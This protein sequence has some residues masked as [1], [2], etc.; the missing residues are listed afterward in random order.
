MR[1]LGVLGA[2]AALLAAYLLFFD[3]DPRDRGAR[4]PDPLL[5]FD[6]G[7][8]RR[9]TVARA[10]QP[11]FVLLRAADGTWRIQP[12]DVPA[13]RPAVEELLNAVAQ[14]ESDRTADLSAAAAGLAPPR[15]ALSIEDAR[16]LAE[17]RLGRADA[18][19]SGVFVQAGDAAVVR[20]GPRHLLELADRPSS[21]L[22]DRHPAAPPPVHDAAAPRPRSPMALDFAHFDA[23]E[24]RRTGPHGALVARSPDG[25]TWTSQ[26]PADSRAIARVVGALGNLKAAEWL[27]RPPAGPPDL[28]LEVAIQAPGDPAPVPQTVDVWPNCVAS[29]KNAGAFRVAQDLCD[30]LRLDPASAKQQRR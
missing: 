2:V 15:V 1:A 11:P 9:V 16:G 25:E 27:P 14:A 30:E 29:T 13:D 12:D 6:P 17:L 3:H 23:R 26:P 21:A 24:L 10:G 22:H 4:A 5:R 8:V 7:S 28:V 20:V 19:G 18:S